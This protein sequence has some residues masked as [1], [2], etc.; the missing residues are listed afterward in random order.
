MKEQ[1]QLFS[2][3]SAAAAL[4]VSRNTIYALMKSGSLKFVKIGADR[5]I[6]AEEIE[7][8]AGEGASIKAP[9]SP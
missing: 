7:R 3:N 2:P 5:R 1:R 9:G 8:I 4:D 6:P